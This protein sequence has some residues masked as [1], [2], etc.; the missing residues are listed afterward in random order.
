MTEI[1]KSEDGLTLEETI[2]LVSLITGYDG[3]QPSQAETALWQR[4]SAIGRWTYDLAARAV[5]EHFASSEAY[6][7]PLHVTTRIR[8]L[9]NLEAE[10]R[11]A[12]AEQE[13]VAALPPA[14]PASKELIREIVTGLAHKLGWPTDDDGN[15]PGPEDSPLAIPC[16]FPTCHA[17]VGTFCR[18]HRGR[19][20]TERSF[21]PGREEAWQRHLDAG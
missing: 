12:M 3:R 5:D 15:Y 19:P 10:R 11:D 21:H 2:D 16:D 9:R 8:Q 14:T 20:L 13:R 6:L 1:E 17:P 7:M 18:G 4:Q